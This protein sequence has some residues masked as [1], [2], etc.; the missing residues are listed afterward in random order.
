LGLTE[1]EFVAL[2]GV[3][4]LGRHVTLLDMPKACLKNLTAQCIEDAPVSL[5]FVTASVDVF[6]NSYFQAL[7]DWYHRDIT[8]PG[9]VAFLPTDVAM[10]V[11]R[12]LRRHVERLAHDEARFSKIY[13][14]AYQKLVDTTAT[15][16]GRY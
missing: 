4:G 3:H 8:G 11:D 10:V 13:T 2:S 9:Q 16:K 1:E 15:T 5:P 6:D 14:R 12:G 7:L